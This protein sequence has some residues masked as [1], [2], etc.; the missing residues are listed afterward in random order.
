MA[1]VD[2]VL[3]YNQRKWICDSKLQQQIMKSI[4]GDSSGGCHFGRDK[5]REK[6]AKRY[7]WHGIYQDVDSFVKTCVDCQKVCNKAIN[8]NKINSLCF[9]PKTNPIFK[10][11][12]S[13]LKPIPISSI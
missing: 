4:H 2:G 5:T 11:P 6:I 8:S 3:H 13:S 12:F 9:S 1:L 10:K 7:Y